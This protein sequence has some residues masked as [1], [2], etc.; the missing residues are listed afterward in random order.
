MKIRTALTLKNTCATAT[1]FLI[2]LTMIYVVSEHT[3]SRTFFHD[4]RG[5][6]ITK[7]HLFLQNQV[8]ARTMQSIY[9]NNRRFINEV[10]VAVYTTDF[11]MLYHD[12]IQNDIIKEDRKMIDRILE[13][14]EIEF[15]IG[16]YQALGMLY[17]FQG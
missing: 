11:H 12:A 5:E 7:A 8:D 17:Q 16:S 13:E 14:K 1:V 2:C 15:Y 4:L 3:R 10:E 9:L 6:A